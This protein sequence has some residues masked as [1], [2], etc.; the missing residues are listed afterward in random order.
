MCHTC[1]IKM[2]EQG[3]REKIGSPLNFEWDEGEDIMDSKTKL[4]VLHR[5]MDCHEESLT[6]GEPLDFSAH[7]LV[8]TPGDVAEQKPLSLC[9]T[10]RSVSLS[11]ESQLSEATNG[12]I[13]R[14]KKKPRGMP[15]RPLS[16]YNLFFQSERTKILDAA[17][18]AGEKIGFEGLGKIIGKKWKELSTADRKVYEDLADKDTVRYRKEM[19]T[20]HEIKTKKIEEERFDS[21]PSLAEPSFE[22]DT[23]EGSLARAHDC[24]TFFQHIP[25]TRQSQ[26]FTDSSVTPQTFHGTPSQEAFVQLDITGPPARSPFSP[27]PQEPEFA[28]VNSMLPDVFHSQYSGGGIQRVAAPIFAH[29]MQMPAPPQGG[30]Q[31]PIPHSFHMPPGMEIVLSDHAGQD[32]KYMVKYTCYSMSRDAAWKYIEGFTSAPSNARRSSRGPSSH[33][34]D[35]QMQSNFGVKRGPQ[36]Y[37][38]RRSHMRIGP[39][40]SSHIAHPFIVLLDLLSRHRMDGV[41]TSNRR[42]WS[43][44]FVVTG[45]SFL[46]CYVIR[47]YISCYDFLHINLVLACLFRFLVVILA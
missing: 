24:D 27:A 23:T 36:G 28:P 5:F 22:K 9:S 6:G 31:V 40:V 38:K 44:R 3:K 30:E 41:Q 4:E 15:K 35:Q 21:S 46:W 19:E 1:R 43:C 12:S 39:W 20:Y 42:S 34:Q 17:Q 8:S 26:Q 10:K 14:R 7:R 25:S 2:N 16:A 13:A 18:G 33:H 47:C 32:R 11:N 37:V 45:G 29:Q